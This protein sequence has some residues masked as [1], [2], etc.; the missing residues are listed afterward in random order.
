MSSVDLDAVF[1][2]VFYAKNKKK[3]FSMGFK[4]NSTVI[5]VLII[6]T[7]SGIFF[8]I[9][10]HYSF[11]KIVEKFKIILIKHFHKPLDIVKSKDVLFIHFQGH[12]LD[13]SL[14]KN[15]GIKI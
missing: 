12:Y 2:D 15:N 3:T 14:S 5:F 9:F 13:S 8:F 1:S 4:G 11:N 10:L 7:L 6:F